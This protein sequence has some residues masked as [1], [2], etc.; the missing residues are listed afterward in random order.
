MS[1]VLDKKSFKRL[2]LDYVPDGEK[3]TQDST[4]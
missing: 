2:D 4:E 1:K 3:S